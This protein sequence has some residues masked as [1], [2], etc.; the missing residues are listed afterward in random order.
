M[1]ELYTLGNHVLMDDLQYYSKFN[2]NVCHNYGK[3]PNVTIYLVYENN[4]EDI[5]MDNL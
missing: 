5:Q 1:Y 3:R 2:Y 4:W